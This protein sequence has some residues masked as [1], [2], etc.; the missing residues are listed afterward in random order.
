MGALKTG[1]QGSVYKGKR[2]GEI[3]TAVKLLP[4]PIISETLDDKHFHDFQNEVNKLKKVNKDPNPNV[5]KI[6][7]SGI[8]ET[9]SF[10]FIEMEFIEG[11][12]LEELLKPP[13]DPVFTIKEVIKVAEH[14]SNALAHCHKVDVKHGDVK[15]NNV[16]FNIHSGNYILL[17]FGMAMMSDEQRRTSLRHAGAIEFMA[18]EQNEG[19]MLL[20]TDIYSCGVILFELLAGVVPFPLRDRGETSRNLV[21]VAHMESPVPDVLNLRRQ[22]MP[23]AWPQEKKDREMQV[24]EWLVRMIYK[25]LEKSSQAYYNNS[26]NNSHLVSSSKNVPS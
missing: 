16:K 14:L 12:D 24:P 2:K 13:H 22:H 10:P 19:K 25:C 23:L 26:N 6:L 20:Q 15:S 18:P 8:T 9:G 17:D 5:V 7:S 1:G 3:I 21:M 4:T 11:P